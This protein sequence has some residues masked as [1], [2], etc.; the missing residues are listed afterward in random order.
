MFTNQVL[1]EVIL[2]VTGMCTI[3]YVACPP[4]EMSVAF[5]LMANPIGLALEGFWLGAFSKRAG[6]G[7]DVFVDVLGP[8]RGLCELFDLE[9]DGTFKFSWQS[10]DRRLGNSRR[11]LRCG[12]FAFCGR[13]VAGSLI[14]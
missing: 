6:K 1:N 13:V 11:E 8:I 10:R 4:F 5:I 7:V 14:G 3:R 12:H 2:T 9:T